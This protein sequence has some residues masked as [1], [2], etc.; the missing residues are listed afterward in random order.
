[1]DGAR[2][3]PGLAVIAKALGSSNLCLATIAAVQLRMPDLSDALASAELHIEA[4]MLRLDRQREA[5]RRYSEDQ[6]RWPAGAPESQGGR[7][8]P[9]D[10]GTAGSEQ[11]AQNSRDNSSPQSASKPPY[12]ATKYRQFTRM[13]GDGEC[14]PLVE[15]ATGAPVPATSWR[16]GKSLADHPD[17][18]EG[19]AIATFVNGKYPNAPAGNHAAIF[20]RYAT[21]NGRDAIIIDA[22]IIY[23]QYWNRDH[24]KHFIGERPIYF[25]NRRPR[26]NNAYAYSVVR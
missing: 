7:F 18:P 16:E 15:K 23:D 20:V 19:T 1:L 8:A 5:L 4:A 11:I 2:L 21:V 17:I 13:V 25:G 24:T 14:V 9:P 12:V 22:I 3:M 6:P 10:A 26:Q